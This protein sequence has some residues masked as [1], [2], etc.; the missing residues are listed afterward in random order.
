[1]S[2]ESIALGEEYKGTRR[3]GETQG[4]RRISAIPRLKDNKAIGVADV[5]TPEEHGWQQSV[6]PDFGDIVPGACE[7]YEG[8]LTKG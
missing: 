5:D 8:Y 4:D 2:G 6:H 1:V 7:R 3:P